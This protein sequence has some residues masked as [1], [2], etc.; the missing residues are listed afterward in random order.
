VRARLLGYFAS[1]ATWMHGPWGPG[2]NNSESF[3]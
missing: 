3:Q 1:Y 2:Q